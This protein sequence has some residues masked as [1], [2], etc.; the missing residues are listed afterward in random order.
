MTGG[1]VNADPD[2]DAAAAPLPRGDGADEPLDGHKGFPPAPGTTLGRAGEA[3]WSLTG[4][5][6]FLPSLVLRTEALDANLASMAAWC[7]ERGVSL[8]PHGK[9]TMAPALW[10]R[11]LDAGAWA[12]TVATLTQLRVA[13]RAGVRRVVLAN[14]VV[15]P[16]GAR[17]LC[18]TL[19][20]D[21]GLEVLVLA[22]SL[23]GT[24]VLAGAAAGHTRQLPVLVEL[25]LPGGR[26]GARTAEQALAVARAVAAAPGLALAGFEAFEGVLHDEADRPRIDAWLDEL[27]RLAAAAETEGLLRGV[28]EV[29]VTAGGSVWFDRVADR[30][31]SLPL[32]TPVRLV[33]RAGC[34]LTHDDGFYATHSPLAG[35]LRPALE[36]WG[37]VLSR[38]EPG[39]AIVGFGKR[40]AAYDIDLPVV[41]FTARQGRRAPAAG[42]TVTALNDQHAFVAV[43]DGVDLAVG[44]LVGCGLSH[45]CTA[46]DKWTCVA[47]VD[48]DDRVV[49]AVRTYF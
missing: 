16:A 29:V 37:A 24:A 46:F 28:G 49:G 45:P 38:P 40:D 31:A 21:P 5:D 3:G 42:L 4:G 20:A 18:D 9:T 36:L 14:E 22:D 25:G 44:D 39:L 32:G 41:R 12:I 30:L 1:R 17:W 34:Y 15:E 2:L 8:A 43:D 47:L 23:A 7:D 35:T 13:L 33:V 27:G 19:D 11:Q 6:L 10:R 48:G 26:T